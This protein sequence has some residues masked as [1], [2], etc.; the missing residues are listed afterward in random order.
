MKEHMHKVEPTPPQHTHPG[1]ALPLLLL[2]Y[3]FSV[4][5]LASN[6][7]KA[8]GLTFDLLLRALFSAEPTEL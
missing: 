4:H 6:A 5:L 7:V 3:S 2:D 8:G 1:F